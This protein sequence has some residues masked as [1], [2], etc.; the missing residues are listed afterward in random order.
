MCVNMLSFRVLMLFSILLSG[1]CLL[2]TYPRLQSGN[3]F[4]VIVLTSLV[5]NSR[6]IAKSNKPPPPQYKQV[7]TTHILV[8]R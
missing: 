7:S 1:G 5:L 8:G 2:H 6:I 3:A 4:C